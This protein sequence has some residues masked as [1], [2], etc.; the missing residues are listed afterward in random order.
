MK[1]YWKDKLRLSVGML[2]KTHTPKYS[3]Y[4]SMGKCILLLLLVLILWM[5]CMDREFVE[6][7]NAEIKQQT[8]LAE[9]RANELGMCVQGELRLV[10]YDE[11]GNPATAI[12]CRKAEEFKI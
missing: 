9:Q 7:A 2:W 12:I 3:D 6:K 4:P 10:A 11:H 8:K 5:W 1:C